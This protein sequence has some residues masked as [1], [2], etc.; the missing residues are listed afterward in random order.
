MPELRVYAKMC[1]AHAR[2]FFI[3][4]PLRLEEGKKKPIC[5]YENCDRGADYYGL[6]IG[7]RTDEGELK[8]E[9]HK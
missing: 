6:I 2:V 3:T 1:E 7:T 5:A 8:G 4:T 9:Y